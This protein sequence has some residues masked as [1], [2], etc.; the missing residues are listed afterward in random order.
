MTPNNRDKHPLVLALCQVRFSPIVKMVD[1]I[2]EL[3][4]LLRKSGFPN[5]EKHTLSSFKIELKLGPTNP[6][7]QQNETVW[8]FFNGDASRSIVVTNASIAVMSLR[9]DYVDSD[10]FLKSLLQGFENLH[11]LA[12]PL[13]VT[14]IGLRYIDLIQPLEDLTIEECLD[15]CVHNEDFMSGDRNAFHTQLQ[16]RLPMKNGSVLALNLRSTNDK[17]AKGPVLTPDFQLYSLRPNFSLEV[18]GPH[19]VLDIDNSFTFTYPNDRVNASD[20]GGHFKILHGHHKK[21]F[22]SATTQELRDIYGL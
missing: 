16:K 2:P 13:A 10:G 14:R 4:D 9:R 20:V 8:E 7:I 6:P 1:Y 18:Q 15:P 22:K 19:A 12:K 17:G 5:Y 21:A 11:E 3:Q